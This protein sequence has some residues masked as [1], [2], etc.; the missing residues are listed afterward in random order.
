MENSSAKPGQEAEP[1]LI[2]ASSISPPKPKGIGRVAAPARV[3]HTLLNQ[4]VTGHLQVNHLTQASASWSIFLAQ[5]QIQFATGDDAKGDRLFYLLQRSCRQIL[6]SRNKALRKAARAPYDYLH[7]CWQQEQ[8]SLQELRSLLRSFSQEALVH[9]LAMTQGRVQFERGVTP[10]PPLMSSD[11]DE[12][13]EPLE[14]Q[15]GQWQV[16]NQQGIYPH[17]RISLLRSSQFAE[18]F[19]GPIQAISRRKGR[20]DLQSLFAGQPTVY[21]IAAQLNGNLLPVAQLMDQAVRL[22]YLRWQAKAVTGKRPHK[23]TV[24]CLD[25]SNAVQQQVRQTLEPLGYRVIGLLHPQQALSI[26][27]KERPCLILMDGALALE[28]E[29]GLGYLLRE[30]PLLRHIPLLLLTPHDSLINSVRA[31]AAGAQGWIVKPMEEASLLK[32]V[33]R[34]AGARSPS[35]AA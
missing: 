35:Q 14:Q 7:Q 32:S 30:S 17:G 18:Q 22:G 4:G 20:L 9:F 23:G 19:A 25:S 31:K 21:G 12:L 10:T 26:L 16:L 11:L 2:Q 27:V 33:R 8:I 6:P 15:I 34:W 13:V 3:L 29:K 24:A 1:T 5:G 28:E